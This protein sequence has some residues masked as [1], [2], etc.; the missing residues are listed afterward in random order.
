MFSFV[1]SATL[2][3]V[4]K[5]SYR[6]ENVTTLQIVQRHFC[7][8][9]GNF[10]QCIVHSLQ[11]R[12]RRSQSRS[13]CMNLVKVRGIH[14]LFSQMLHRHDLRCPR[15]NS[16]G[17]SAIFQV[18]KRT[19]EVQHSPK[20]TQ[21]VSDDMGTQLQICH[22]PKLIPFLVNH[23]ASH[24]GLRSVTS[25]ILFYSFNR[26]L[27]ISTGTSTGFGWAGRLESKETLV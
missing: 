8:W 23:A 21:L 18:S 3:H 9:A 11:G 1:S 16:A 10:L 24:L 17:L 7:D 14:P 20:V 12:L 15:P 6:N 25:V 4:H 26:Q 5:E 27:Q 2:R 19:G 22:I 13:F